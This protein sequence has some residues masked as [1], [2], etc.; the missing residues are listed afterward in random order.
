MII[1]CFDSSD[2]VE[3]EPPCAGSTFGLGGCG[4]VFPPGSLPDCPGSTFGL[5]GFGAGG[6]VTVPLEFN[7]FNASSACCSCVSKTPASFRCNASTYACRSANLFFCL[8]S[9]NVHQCPR[10]LA[11]ASFFSSKLAAFCLASFNSAI[12]FFNAASWA[13]FVRGSAVIPFSFA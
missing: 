10:S 2:N 11:Y 7:A 8:A 5:G 13:S 12:F 1:C 9:S 3:P 4:S 6:G